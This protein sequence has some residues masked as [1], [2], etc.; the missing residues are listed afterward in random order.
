MDDL[1][2]LDDALAAMPE[3]VQLAPI[4]APRA[5]AHALATMYPDLE[6]TVAGFASGRIRMD[7]PGDRGDL[8]DLRYELDR[9]VKLL[10]SV[11]GAIDSVF[12]TAARERGA[13]EI[14]LPDDRKVVYEAPRGSYTGD[15]R[16]MRRELAELAAL[17]GDLPPD[18]VQDALREE[19]VVT[20]D[21]R[22]LNA[23]KARY[24]ARAGAIIDGHR[25]F[26]VEGTGRVRYPR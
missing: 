22:K 19:I 9:V 15:F 3:Q 16:A 18:I 8:A 4:V 14:P 26:V 10:S 12:L 11:R 20:P 2:D 6:Q 1:S 25:T 24:G 5:F 13:K 21:H 7:E 23:I 17:H